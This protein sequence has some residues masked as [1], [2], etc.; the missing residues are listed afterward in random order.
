MAKINLNFF[1]K[2]PAHEKKIT[3]STVLTLVRI[4]LAPIIVV[5]MI[6]GSWG[7]AFICFVSASLTDMLDGNLARMRGEKTF[8]GAFLDPIA[9][10]VLI[11]SCFFTLAFVHTPLF[12]VPFWFVF[13]VLFKEMVLLCGAVLFYVVCG[14]LPIN[15]TLLGKLTTVMQMCFVIWLFACYFFQ[16]MPVKTYYT[17]LGLLII[18]VFASL[19]QYARRAFSLF[20]TT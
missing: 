3:I 5:L 19:A 6:Y 15:P 18:L 14:Y 12:V 1:K 8:L 20:L 7:A 11:L 9:D 2:L 4:I 16:W 17:M 10:K 13:L